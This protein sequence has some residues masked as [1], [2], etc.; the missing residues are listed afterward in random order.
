MKYSLNGK[1][2]F[3]FAGIISQKFIIGLIGHLKTHF[4]AM[5][6]LY[7]ILKDSTDPPTDD[8]LAI[9]S[10]KKVLDAEAANA[11]LGRVETASANLLSMFAKQSQENAVSK[12]WFL[13]STLN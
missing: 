5:H 1:P 2:P 10:G 11:Y 12:I 4:P 6:R 8:E 3:P 7:N 13:I 9:A